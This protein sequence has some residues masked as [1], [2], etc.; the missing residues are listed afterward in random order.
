VPGSV[1]GTHWR[2]SVGIVIG[3]V[4][5]GI[6]M[7]MYAAFTVLV[8]EPFGRYGTMMP[9]GHT[10]IYLDR[11][12]ADGPFHVDGPGC[13]QPGVVLAKYHMQNCFGMQ[14]IGLAQ[15]TRMP[16]S[17]ELAKQIGTCTLIRRHR[18]CRR[19]EF[20]RSSLGLCDSQRVSSPF[21]I[22]PAN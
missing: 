12:C 13:E 14:T 18:G 9:L 17:W 22:S 4:L 6:A 20:S 21:G 7:P 2:L 5:M 15:E 10:A 1:P 16:S 3:A 19:L 8:G 11:V